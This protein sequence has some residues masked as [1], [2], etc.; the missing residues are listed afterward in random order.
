[1]AVLPFSRHS[2]DVSVNCAAWNT[3]RERSETHG[4]Q[5]R[6]RSLTYVPRVFRSVCSDC[7]G[8]LPRTA[9]ITLAHCRGC[10]PMSVP[11]RSIIGVPERTCV[12]FRVFLLELGTWVPV[13]HPFVDERAACL[14]A[15]LLSIQH[16][17][18]HSVRQC[19]VLLH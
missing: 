14:L 15:E 16:Q 2:Q 12:M 4:T 3:E 8:T 19:K 18:I 10:V 17:E 6:E 5:E 1:M 13:S 7:F 9:R 11:E